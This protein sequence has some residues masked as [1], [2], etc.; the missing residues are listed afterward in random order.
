MG[1]HAPVEPG[2]PGSV[3]LAHGRGEPGP[4]LREAPAAAAAAPPA[5]PGRSLLP[6][7]PLGRHACVRVG[8]QATA[9]G[10]SLGPNREDASCVS[11]PNSRALG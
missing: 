6:E 4:A 8:L 10:S 5:P 1:A 2:E 3:A 7:D 11:L 9:Q